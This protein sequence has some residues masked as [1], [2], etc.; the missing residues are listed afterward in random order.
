ME[1]GASRT[2][3]EH[4]SLRPLSPTK[5]L[6]FLSN[7]SPGDV[8]VEALRRRLH[9]APRPL[10]KR[11]SITEPEGPDG[12]NIQKL[13]YQKTTLAAMETVPMD[14]AGA[15]LGEGGGFRDGQPEDESVA[16]PPLPP[17]SPDPAPRRSP[18]PPLEDREEEEEEDEG[19]V[20][21]FPPYPPPPYPSCG[22]TEPGDDVT[23]QVS[24][25]VSPAWGRGLRP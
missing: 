16:P 21:Q 10:K 13:L 17:R 4:A 24:L 5:L 18:L 20:D 3:E 25:K 1:A 9:H 23:V 7:R 8:D 14:T 15:Q 19:L 11:S 6:P 2:G 12:P 22:E